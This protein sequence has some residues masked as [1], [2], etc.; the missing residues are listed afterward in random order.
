M[1]EQLGT[2]TGNVSSTP[3]ITAWFCCFSKE[4]NGVLAALSW[5]LC[6]GAAHARVFPLHVWIIPPVG[7][8]V[9]TGGGA[10]QRV[11]T[12]HVEASKV[13]HWAGQPDTLPK[14][15]HWGRRDTLFS[16]SFPAGAVMGKTCCRGNWEGGGG[17]GG[18]GSISVCL[19]MDHKR[20]LQE[21]LLTHD[22][23]IWVFC[24]GHDVTSVFAFHR[25]VFSPWFV[26]LRVTNYLSDGLCWIWYEGFKFGLLGQSK[27]QAR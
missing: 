14:D 6:G 22:Q 13:F 26:V 24:R 21:F 3:V 19:C 8:T 9:V 15:L 5:T 7:G 23:K 20:N 10:L 17:K 12:S 1:W 2:A 18:G 27:V 16:N 11:F 4:G 25:A